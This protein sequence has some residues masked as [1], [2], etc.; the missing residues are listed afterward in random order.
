MQQLRARSG[1][2]FFIVL[3]AVLWG[4]AGIAS[5]FIYGMSDLSSIWVATWRVALAAPLLLLL[6]TVMVGG[7]WWRVQS[8]RDLGIMGLLGLGMAGYQLCYF[9]AIAEMGVTIAVLVDLC[10]AP[11]MVALL[12]GILLGERLTMPTFV[13]LVV[14]IVGTALLI[15]AGPA[16]NSSNVQVTTSGVLL[17]LGAGFFYAVMTLCGRVL[18]RRYHPLQPITLAFSFAAVLMLVAA[19]LTVGG[20]LAYALPVWGWLL[21]LGVVPTALGYFF[22][23]SG[24][25]T[26]SATVASV[27][28]LLEPLTAAVLAW[29]LFDE[30]LGAGGIVGGVLLLISMVILA[31]PPR[32]RQ[33]VTSPS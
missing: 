15:L 16:A 4:T 8:R 23:L 17:A 21:Y 9:Q 18:S 5:R 7:D 13:A 30:R 22:F 10:S 12:A 1:G 26:V 3:T 29:L 25:K 28:T 6:C 32:P 11:I 24:L 20:S 14:A 31:V 27:A 2:L 33:A 19:S